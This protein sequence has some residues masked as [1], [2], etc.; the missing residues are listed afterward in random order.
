MIKNDIYSVNHIAKHSFSADDSKHAT[1]K[2]LEINSVFQPIFSLVHKRIV[3]YEA[4][5]R[6]QDKQEQTVRPDLLFQ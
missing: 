4:L 5:V 1:F 6:A 3:G 2:D